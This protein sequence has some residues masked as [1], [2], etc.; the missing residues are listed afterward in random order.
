ML[1]SAIRMDC[2]PV[3]TIVIAYETGTK[4]MLALCL[5]NLRRFTCHPYELIVVTRDPQATAEVRDLALAGCL[6]GKVLE[7]QLSRPVLEGDSSVHAEMLDQ[8]IPERIATQLVLTLDSDCFPVA[9]GWLEHLVGLLKPGI[10]CVG[11]LHPYP[12]PNMHRIGVL[13]RIEREQS[14]D[15]T[16]VACQ[17]VRTEPW[18]AKMKYRGGLD[19]G[20]AI[21]QYFKDSGLRCDGLQVTRG[22][23]ASGPSSDPELNRE[24]CLVFGDMVYH[25][26]GYTRFQSGI[27]DVEVAPFVEVRN[28]VLESGSA[29]FLLDPTQSH[30]FHFQSE[31]VVASARIQRLRRFVPNIDHL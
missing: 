27:V 18:S 14:Y 13:G 21:P 9:N 4:T 1:E 28:R 31:S 24:F 29:E 2:P 3:V 10:G 22:P 23:L 7:V 20:L 16:H 26:A 17:L 12:R 5:A 19:T 8:V 15:T 30:V 11:I 6:D 25:H